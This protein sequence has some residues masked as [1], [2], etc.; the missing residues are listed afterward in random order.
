MAFLDRTARGLLLGEIVSGLAVTLRCLF[1]PKA[2]SNYPMEKNAISPRVRGV[3]DRPMGAPPITSPR[4]S[5]SAGLAWSPRVVIGASRQAQ[6]T[7][8]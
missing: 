6:G 5:G 2:T 3:V 8:A 7:A 1:K 4:P